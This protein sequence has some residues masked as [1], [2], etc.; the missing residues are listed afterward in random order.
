MNIRTIKDLL[1]DAVRLD[2]ET[3]E[4]VGPAGPSAWPFVYLHDYQDMAGW[5]RTLG[6]KKCQL[7]ADDGDPYRAVRRAFWDQ[8]NRD[9]SPE[10]ISR[11]RAVGEW[12]WLIDDEGERRAILGWLKSKVGGKSFRRWCKIEGIS[13]TTGLKRKNRALE[14][15][16]LAL[17]RSGRLHDIVRLPEGLP[18]DPDFDDLS[19]TIAAGADETEGIDN[20]NAAD[21]R[22][23]A[24][25]NVPPSAFTWAAKQNAR[26]RQR[27]AARRAKESK[28]GQ[29][30]ES[31]QGKNTG[32]KP[33]ISRT[34]AG[35]MEP[36]SNSRKNRGTQNRPSRA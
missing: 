22:P 23:P 24:E 21:A 32:Q 10:E 2:R 8:Y 35:Q 28:N 1:I 31:C 12:V 11:A 9:P 16:F 27:E 33:D 4:H 26:R 18:I 5:G 7:D 30:A 14:K 17:A 36:R 29:P 20:W 15:I 6:D 25:A 34:N 3:H 13:Q 19:A